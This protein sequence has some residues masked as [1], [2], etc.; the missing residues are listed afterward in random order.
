MSRAADQDRGQRIAIGIGVVVQ[1][2]PSRRSSGLVFRCRVA[3]IGDDGAGGAGRV[4]DWRDGDGDGGGSAVGLAVVGF[5][6]EAVRT[7][8]IERRGVGEATVAVQGQ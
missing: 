1:P 7:V 4:V 5:V 8:V 3:V 2:S 6:R